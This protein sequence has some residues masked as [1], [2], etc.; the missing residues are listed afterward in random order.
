[1]IYTLVINRPGFLPESG[2]WDFPS[3]AQARESLVDWVDEAVNGDPES[4]AYLRI[5]ARCLGPNI[6]LQLR[7]VGDGNEYVAE[8]VE[9]DVDP[10][11]VID[12][13]SEPLAS[14]VKR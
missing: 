12:D 3:L 4:H 5:A 14:E 7:G 10:H 2:P 8:I 6:V 13:L 9:H 11:D 1:M